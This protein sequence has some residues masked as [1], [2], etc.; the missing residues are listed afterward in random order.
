MF[1]NFSDI[2]KHHNLFLDYL[3]EFENVAEYFKHDFRNKDGYLPLFK[4]IVESKKNK[5]FVI[6]PILKN[7]YS[8][9]NN[10]SEKTLR[11][12]SSLDDAKTIA[13]VTGQQLGILGGPLY[14]LY[15]IITTIRLANQLSERYEEYNFI[16]VFW[17][18]ADDH[19]FNEVR[20]VNL[21]DNENQVINIGYKEQISDDDSKQ[22]M[23]KI[24]FDESLNDFLNQ[25]ENSLRDTDF[26]NDLLLKIKECYKV[27]ISFKQSFKQL[28][29]WLFDEYGVVIFDPQDAEVKA[30]LK[31]IFTKEVNDFSIQTQKLI[32]T[33]A[34]LEEDY[35]AQVKVKPVNLF[36]HTDDGRYSI[37]PV[38]GIFKL[39]RKRKQFTKEEILNE[40]ENAPE[41]FSPNV[42]LRPICQDY[43]LPTGFY[44]AGPSEISYFAQ[45]TPLY[46]FYKIVTPIVYPRSS[47]TI[48]EKN[49]ESAMDKY[50]LTL[51]DIFL[52]LDELKEKVIAGLSENNIEKAFEDSVNEIDL[53][54]DKLKE[55]LFAIDKT[56]VDSS[57]RYRERVLSSINE[58]KSKATKAQENK[59][60]TTIRQLTR[61]SNLLYPLENLQ[62][63]EINFT[64]FYNKHGKELIK[65][66]YNDISISEF[67]HQII[68]L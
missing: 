62:E 8:S 38:E 30:L 66:I 40:I 2:P 43:L 26:K 56:L 39:R 1:I 36:Y 63:R 13:V 3:Y 49:V 60:E 42:L 24:N 41:R 37:E 7:Q 55:N 34:K 21:F 9:F 15:K 11:N 6:S 28:L 58:L 59:H 27:G 48:M 4:D 23:G 51:T 14:T 29:F 16:P 12:I 35:H 31:P 22:S 44:I 52:G 20:S 5:S 68:S 32:Q 65:K 57:L 17:M 53:T 50:D 33:S 64:Y 18:E 54:F 67:E 10:I 47:V 19:D 46:N 25:F 45:V 61:L